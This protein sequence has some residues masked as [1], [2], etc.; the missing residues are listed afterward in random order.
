M[1]SAVAAQIAVDEINKDGGIDGKQIQLYIE[2]DQYNT[3]KSIDAYNKLVHVDG[4]R[5]L[6]RQTYGAVF[7]LAK[8]AKRDGVTIF[9]SLDCNT[10]LVGL[11]ENVFCLATGS[12]TI[13]ES[14]ASEVKSRNLSRMGVLY[15]NSD[16]FMP[17]VKDAFLKTYKG[18]IIEEGYSAGTKDFRTSL[19][20]MKLANVQAV[21]FFGYDETGIAMKEARTLG[22]TAPFFSTATITS[23]SLQQLASGAAIG[24]K[25]AY[26]EG[27]ANGTVATHFLSSFSTKVGRKPILDLATYS[28]YDI[29][30]AIVN[31]LR[32]GN[33]LT[34][35]AIS[36]QS[37][38]GA[39][40]Q[41]RFAVDGSSRMVETLYILTQN[42][43]K[44]L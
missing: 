22:I 14:I 5:I 19:L 38:E 7:A 26:W 33:P 20:K 10:P 30:Y 35:A 3:R 23:P 43:I 34:K 40:G 17:Y 8:D 27:G 11:G 32:E 44:R 2:D 15:F 28:T 1:D 6:I 41:V 25:F 24:T 36:K 42:G 4:V 21:V 18:T 39:T 12:E 16:P 13:G 37:F 9:D 31:T 29:V